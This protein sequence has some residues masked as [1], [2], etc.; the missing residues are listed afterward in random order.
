MRALSNEAPLPDPGAAA[1]Q[2][3]RES[4]SEFE[5]QPEASMVLTPHVPDR[6][7]A[8]MLRG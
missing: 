1:A 2:H 5:A 4:A 8:L 3:T 6:T 7:A